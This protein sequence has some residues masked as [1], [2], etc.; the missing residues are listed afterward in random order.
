M[1]AHA[2]D[3]IV[4]EAV[5]L[6]VA[7]W[8]VRL[9]AAGAGVDATPISTHGDLGDVDVEVGHGLL[10]GPVEIVSGDARRAHLEG[11]ALDEDHGLHRW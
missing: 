1:P 9:I 7:L 2:V 11:A 10:V 4:I 3:R 8:P 5:A 6:H